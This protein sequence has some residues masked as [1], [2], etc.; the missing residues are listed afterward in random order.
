MNGK[1]AG[2][3]KG[4]TAMF[5]HGVEPFEVGRD[6]ISP[7]YPGYK[8]QGAFPFSGKIETIRFDLVR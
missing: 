4:G 2:A 7:V 6:S 3:G 8:G 5:R 1:P